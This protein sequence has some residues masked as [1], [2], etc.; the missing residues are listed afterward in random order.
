MRRLRR[1][2]IHDERGLTLVEVVVVGVLAAIVMLG[3]TGF[4]IN[5]QGTWIEAS[6]QAVTQREAT[7]VLETIADQAHAS[8][9][10]DL[11]TPNC[12]V[13]YAT[14]PPAGGREL[15]RFWVGADSLMHQGDPTVPDRGPMSTSKVTRFDLGGSDDSSMVKILALEMRSANGRIIRLSSNVAFLNRPPQP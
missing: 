11:T 6:S 4:Y 5:S 7:I 13:L 1:T 12:L 2:R 3:M 14:G 15:C 8:Y 9:S 10:A